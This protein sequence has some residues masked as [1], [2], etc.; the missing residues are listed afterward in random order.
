MHNLNKIKHTKKCPHKISNWDSNATSR[1]FGWIF[2][3]LLVDDIPIL[4]SQLVRTFLTHIDFVIVSVVLRQLYSY[5]YLSLEIE[6]RR[7]SFEKTLFRLNEAE[8]LF[9]R[10]QCKKL[11]KNRFI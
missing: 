6:I 9:S 2:V 5:V 8:I 10:N 11:C 1:L 7:P 3:V 4:L